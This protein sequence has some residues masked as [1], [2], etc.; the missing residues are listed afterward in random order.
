MVMSPLSKGLF[1]Q[2]RTPGF[3]WMRYVPFKGYATTQIRTEARYL[4]D[5]AQSM[6][7]GPKEFSASMYRWSRHLVGRGVQSI[8]WQLLGH[9][10]AGGSYEEFK[11]RWQENP[12]GELAVAVTTAMFAGSYGQMAYGFMGDKLSGEDTPGALAAGIANSLWPVS[13]AGDVF[14]V[15]AQEGRYEGMD[16]FEALLASAKRWY[17]QS[18]DIMALIAM[19]GLAGD[20]AKAE[21]ELRKHLRLFYRFR[22]G[23]TPRGFTLTPSSRRKRTSEE[24]MDA[25]DE[26]RG[27]ILES[28]R[29]MREF[30]YAGAKRELIEA[31]GAKDA[32]AARR[33][34]LAR[35]V[36][37]TNDDPL[38]RLSTEELATYKA[39]LTPETIKTIQQ[40]DRLLETLADWAYDPSTKSPESTPAPGRS[41]RQR[42][43]QARRRRQP[44]AR[45]QSR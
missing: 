21:H 33:S 27:A 8:T 43:R 4:K 9:M 32:K 39:A 19:S 42:G 20:D 6:R 14:N 37:G 29:R 25:R 16:V 36:L 5:I 30:D 17:P 28:V 24:E 7:Q 40:Y 34:I 22:H 12:V 2:G 13:I 41:L 26:F 45:R 38:G 15:A 3:R 10:L 35:R 1:E 23:P 18:R 31:I 11:K 44:R